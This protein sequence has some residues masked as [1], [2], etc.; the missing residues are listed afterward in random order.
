M[1]RAFCCVFGPAG[2]Q[3]SRVTALTAG[4]PISSGIVNP[5]GV[6][7]TSKSVFFAG[8][9]EEVFTLLSGTRVFQ[10]NGW[11]CLNLCCDVVAE[12]TILCIFAFFFPEQSQL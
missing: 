12:W 2:R 10:Q 7:M 5:S 11:H 8:G 1:P 6:H 3:F 4:G 9:W